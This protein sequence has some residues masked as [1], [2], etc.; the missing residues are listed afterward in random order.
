MKHV[1]GWVRLVAVFGVA[2]S[3]LLSAGLYLTTAVRAV[4]LVLI[5]LNDLGRETTVKTLLIAGIELAD[6][7]LVATGLLIVAIGL[8]SLFIDRLDGLPSWLHIDSFDAL[9]NKLVSVVVAALAVRFFSI[10]MEGASGENVMLYGIAIAAV[11]IG[12][13][14]YALAGAG[15]ERLRSV[16]GPSRAGDR[17]PPSR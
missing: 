8:Y 17:R 5:S 9:K 1:F 11:L 15:A 4:L 10:V 13:A 7:L 6:A 14:A 12:L 2:A 3:A 16:S